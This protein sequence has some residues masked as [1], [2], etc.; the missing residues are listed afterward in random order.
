MAIGRKGAAGWSVHP[1]EILREE[2]LAP[3]KLT[4]NRL[5]RELHVSAPTINDI[6]LERRG[7]T[8]ETAVL[9]GRYFDMSE[10][11]WLNLQS[12]YDVPRTKRRLAAKLKLIKPLALHARAA[13]KP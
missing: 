11:F 5:A 6:V 9:L 2:F 4:S 12:A 7:V 3:M 1:G 13:G 8:A 10:Q